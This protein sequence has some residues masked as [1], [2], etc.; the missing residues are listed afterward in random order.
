METKEK[1]VY[2]SN[3]KSIGQQ[4]QGLR[5]RLYEEKLSEHWQTDDKGRRYIPFNVWANREP[6]QYG[7]THTMILDTYKPTQQVG[8]NNS[9]NKDKYTDLPF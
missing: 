8:V 5:G 3:L 2:L 4:N 9:L 6:D 7:N 1:K